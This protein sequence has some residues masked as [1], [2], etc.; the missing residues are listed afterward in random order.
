MENY[1]ISCIFFNKTKC[2]L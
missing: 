2:K 1:K